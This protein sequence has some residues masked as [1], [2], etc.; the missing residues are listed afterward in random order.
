[1]AYFSSTK[2][3]ALIN[4]IRRTMEREAL[5][6]IL[7]ELAAMEAAEYLKFKQFHF[8]GRNGAGSITVTGTAVGDRVIL[9][10]NL[11]DEAAGGAAFETTITVVNQIQQSSASDLSAKKF[12][13]LVYRP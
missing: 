2:R 6:T 11:T 7:S 10:T 5:T 1:M 13:L 12:A 8:T 3:A 9:L 4:A